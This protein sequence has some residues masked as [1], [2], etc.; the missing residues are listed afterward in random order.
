MSSRQWLLVNLVIVLPA[1]CKED[2]PTSVEDSPPEVASFTAT[3]SSVAWGES[4]LF[5]FKATDTVVGEND[6]A[7]IE[8]E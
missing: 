8:N 5:Y 1:G 6:K 3:P 4:G 7:L 2:A